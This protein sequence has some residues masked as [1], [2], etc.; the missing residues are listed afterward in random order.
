M[1]KLNPINIR[2]SCYL[3]SYKNQLSEEEKKKKYIPNRR[4]AER[5]DCIKHPLVNDLGLAPNF[6]VKR[7]STYRNPAKEAI[8]CL[9]RAIWKVHIL[10]HG[11]RAH[12]QHVRKFGQLQA[13][14]YGFR[15]RNC[16]HG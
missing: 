9:Q 11:K 13:S 5:S 14:G 3:P 4:L 2:E 10:C 15:S 7:I 8:R 12:L 16:S 1:K 6:K